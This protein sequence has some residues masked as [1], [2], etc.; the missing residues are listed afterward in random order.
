[1]SIKYLES[2]VLIYII[3]HCEMAEETGPRDFTENKDIQI[4]CHLNVYKQGQEP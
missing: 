4:I 2:F 1:M 3:R